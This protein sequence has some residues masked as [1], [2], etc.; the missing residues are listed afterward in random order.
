M[1]TDAMLE[2]MALDPS[3]VRE[4]LGHNLSIT[5]EMLDLL[6]RLGLRMDGYWVWGD[7]AYNKGMFFSPAMYRDI[8]RPFHRELL[9]RLGDIVITGGVDARVISS[10]DKGAIEKEIRD[11]LLHAKQGKYIYHSDHSI[12][13]DVTLDTYR[14][15]IDMVKGYGAASR[16]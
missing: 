10:N 5:F 6:D 14:F 15:V 7:I 12:A 16:V 3:F 9:A 8:L 2:Q 1:G 4:M 11:K 13:Y